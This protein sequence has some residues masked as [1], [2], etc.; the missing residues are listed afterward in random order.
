TKVI[1]NLSDRL[2][3]VRS[4]GQIQGSAGHPRT[5]RTLAIK[6]QVIARVEEAPRCSTR[7]IGRTL[8]IH[9]NLVGRT[10]KNENDHH[11]V[12]LNLTTYYLMVLN[13]IEIIITNNLTLVVNSFL[14]CCATSEEIQNEIDS[15]LHC[16]LGSS[17]FYQTAIAK[18]EE[19]TNTIDEESETMCS[20][21]KTHFEKC[22]KPVVRLF[23]ECL[24]EK[25]REIPS[26]VTRSILS[27]SEHLCKTDG[28]H[29][30]ELSNP[31]VRSQNYKTKRCLRRIQSKLQ[32]YNSKVPSKEEIC[33]FMSSF[34]GCFESHLHSSC[35][36][37]KTREAFLNLYNAALTPCQ[38]PAL[39][40]IEL[41]E[42]H[43][44]WEVAEA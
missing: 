3:F 28:E 15:L 23:E 40:E 8:G 22:S 10:I 25:S 16:L 38:G 17:L 12:T 7:H 27:V 6:K 43:R 26:F 34:K 14:S 24:P 42:P 44:E 11:I 13:D 36:H 9:N 2:R 41:L 39:N 20:V 32:Q 29:I 18:V 37:I 4:M 30:F 1:R 5:T 21:I 33:E 31:C 35:G 19:C